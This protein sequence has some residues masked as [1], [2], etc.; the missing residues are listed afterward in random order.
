MMFESEEF[1]ER[2]VE[3]FRTG[4]SRPFTLEIRPTNLCNLR[5]PSCVARG[6]PHEHLGQELP[7]EEY[8]RIID[9]AVELG[10][11]YAQISGG[12][13]PFLY[14]GLLEIMRRIKANGMMGRVI[15]NGTQFTR[16][17]IE[18]IVEMKWDTILLSLDAPDK[19]LN[20]FLRSKPGTFSKTIG[21]MRQFQAM[22]ERHCAKLPHVNVCTVLSHYTCGM[23]A[24]MVRLCAGM[25]VERIAFQTVHIRPDR[26]AEHFLL[27]D[28]DTKILAREIPRAQ[29]CAQELGILSNL[30]GL[31]KEL[32]MSSNDP[33]EIIMD[34]SN[35]FRDHPKL[36]IPCFSPWYYIGIN[37][38]GRV[39][40]CHILEDST[41]R[42]NVRDTSLRDLWTDSHIG[43]FRET[44]ANRTLLK[45]CQ[46]CVGTQIIETKRL[47]ER[48]I[49]ALPSH[50]HGDRLLKV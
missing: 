23:L 22:K 46:K 35:P 20:D 6:H 9:E 4:K 17:I 27:T 32:I 39:G 42:G 49:H 16:K 15:S 29:E 33:R 36:S 10:V 12:G 25:G 48:L 34:N 3:W 26:G 50:L 45:P 24:E 28:E 38:D 1:M 11:R 14:S 7:K 13:E 19:N 2:M 8:L 30:D 44:L 5:C 31:S 43:G 37:T 40:P 41:Y 47:R 21:A 18:E